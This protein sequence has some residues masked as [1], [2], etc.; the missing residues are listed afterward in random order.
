[1]EVASGSDP[2]GCRFDPCPPSHIHLWKQTGRYDTHVKGGVPELFK[3][4]LRIKQHVRCER[5]HQSGFRFRQDGIVYTWVD[6]D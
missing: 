5:C 3:Y 6:T 1:M 2:E 4:G